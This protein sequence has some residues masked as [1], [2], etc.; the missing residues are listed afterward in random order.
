MRRSSP[1]LSPPWCHR[2]LHGTPPSR[3]AL[4]RRDH[5]TGAAAGHSAGDA[6]G[7]APPVGE[8]PDRRKAGDALP[9]LARAL[10][11]RG[12]V[13]RVRLVELP[14]LDTRGIVLVD[15]S[16]GIVVREHVPLAPELLGPGV[17]GV[18]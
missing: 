5:M 9:V 4:Q 3:T 1:G 15:P 11:V 18:L 2:G 17:V 14:A 12:I 8:S 13:A 10:L 6:L 16:G 7:S